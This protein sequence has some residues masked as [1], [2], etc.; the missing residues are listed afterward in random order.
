SGFSVAADEAGASRLYGGIHW[1]SANLHAQGSGYRIGQQVARYFL[2]PMTALQF[3][4]VTRSPAGTQLEVQGEPFT[5]YA[6]RASSDLETW[7]TIAVISAA[8]GLL[9]FT[10]VNAADEQ[11][12][13]YVAVEQ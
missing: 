7:E 6:I 4:H 1:P 9:R 13:F 12:R 10:D 11:L 5:T 3:S 8:D 2:Q